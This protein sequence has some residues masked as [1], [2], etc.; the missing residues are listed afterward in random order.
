MAVT[1]KGG[2]TFVADR[3][4]VKSPSSSSG[5]SSKGGLLGP[6]VGSLATRI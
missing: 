5:L 2:C 4:V 1:V 6:S 3:P